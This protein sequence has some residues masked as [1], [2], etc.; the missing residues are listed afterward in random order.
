MWADFS[1]RRREDGT[2]VLWDGGPSLAGALDEVPLSDIS[3]VSVMHTLISDA[4][5]AL[6]EVVERWDGPVGAYAHAG[7]FVMPNWRFVDE[8]SP[9][10][11]ADEAAEWHALG[12]RVL[13]G[14]CGIGPE[15]VR[16]LARRFRAS[17]DGIE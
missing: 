9:Q 13:G 12:A 2:V 14:C 8:I 1:C 15:H 5:P 6:G 4:A 3:L 17:G 16:A 7:R 10:G 11:F